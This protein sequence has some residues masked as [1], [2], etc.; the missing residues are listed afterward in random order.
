MQRKWP[1][2]QFFVLKQRGVAMAVSMGTETRHRHL[3]LR[4]QRKWGY[5]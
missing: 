5:V 4:W 1:A 3:P 2:G